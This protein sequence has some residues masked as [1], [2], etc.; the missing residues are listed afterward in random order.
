MLRRPVRKVIC[1][2]P[3]DPKDPGPVLDLRMKLILAKDETCTLFAYLV[4]KS[5][6]KSNIFSKVHFSNYVHYRHK[7]D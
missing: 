5:A 3:L 1:E 4:K 7:V 2:S 6:L